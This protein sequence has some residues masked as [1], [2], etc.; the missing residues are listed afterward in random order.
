M[1]KIELPTN[2]VSYLMTNI[3]L[4]VSV[5]KNLAGNII[6]HMISFSMTFFLFNNCDI[7]IYIMKKMDTK[8]SSITLLWI[9]V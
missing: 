9:L 3:L 8:Y 5:M 6:D 2:Q 4:G 1:K 7:R